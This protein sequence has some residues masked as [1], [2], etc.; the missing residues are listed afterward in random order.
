MKTWKYFFPETDFCP[1]EES[2]NV[3]CAELKGG[4]MHYTW[5]VSF[6]LL[7]VS[8][9]MMI[10]QGSIAGA[11]FLLFFV[12]GPMIVSLLFGCIVS[13]NRSQNL[14]L[15]S[16]LLYFCWFCYFY[17]QAFVSHLDP[18]SVLVMLTV[19]LC[20]LP[21]MI[22]FWVLALCFRKRDPDEHAL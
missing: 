22:P 10:A 1:Q 2:N 15:L 14:L 5:T 7:V 21:V 4:L 18:Q 13:S 9:C 8:I 11:L 6:L 19:G 16:N 12:Q 3:Q 20:F 17:I